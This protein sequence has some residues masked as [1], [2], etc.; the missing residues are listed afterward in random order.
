MRAPEIEAEEGIPPGDELF[1][2]LVRVRL[3]R[4][5]SEE[6]KEGGFLGIDG[7]AVISG[8]RIWDKNKAKEGEIQDLDILAI[9]EQLTPACASLL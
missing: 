1:S 7:M 3:E 4:K 8:G 5:N 9:I 2:S 6:N